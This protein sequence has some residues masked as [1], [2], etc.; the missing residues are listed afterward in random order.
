MHVLKRACWLVV[1]SVL[2][3]C[4]L[5][6]CDHKGDPGNQAHA[7]A[8]VDANDARTAYPIVLVHGMMGFVAMGPLRYWPGITEQLQAHGAQVFTPQ[9]SAFNSSE[10]RGQQLLAEVQAI[11]KQTGAAKV[12]LIGHSQGSQA[13]RYV[14]TMRPDL[15]ASVTAVAGPTFGSETADWVQATGREH[16]WFLSA[17]MAAGD[18]LGQGI[19]WFSGTDLPQDARATLASLSTAGAADFNRHFPAGVPVQACAEGAHEAAGQRFYSWSGVGRFF[20]ALNLADYLM[21]LT[22]QTFSRE[23]NDGLVGRCASHFGQVLR[24]DYPMNHFQA[25]NQFFGLVGPDVDPVRLYLDHARR[26]KEA[27]L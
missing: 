20:N 17:L 27:G 14:A 5:S 22:G 10:L 12:N 8:A 24:D 9:V 3:A 11:L 18:A 7:S 1:A 25:V 21:A 15:V 26:L 4:G 13:A 6:A 19:N 16:P 2:M 23:A